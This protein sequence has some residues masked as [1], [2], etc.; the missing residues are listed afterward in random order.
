M[1]DKKRE[2]RITGIGCFVICAL[3]AYFAIVDMSITS[4]AGLTGFFAALFGVLGGVSLWKPDTWGA[5]ISEYLKRLGKGGEEGSGSSTKQI[6]EKSYG[7]VQVMTGDQAEVHINVP[8]KEKR[9]AEKPSAEEKE[10][11]RK[12][13]IV[14]SPSDGYSY[15]FDLIRGEHL[16]G[17]ITS[18]SP[19]DVL[20]VDEPCFDKW[21]N[22]RKYFEPEYSNDSVLE[23]TIDYVVPQKGKWF[24]IIENNGRKT[25][26]VKVRLY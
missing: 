15:E 24:V 13:T 4:V 21:S 16:R 3:F 22:G 10:I 14:V 20:F 2:G 17:E 8:S 1:E 23:T 18:T 5:D 9:Q 6:Q 7:S 25:A 26:T 11:L 12:E 19:I